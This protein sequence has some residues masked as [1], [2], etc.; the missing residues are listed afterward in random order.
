MGE[1]DSAERTIWTEFQSRFESLVEQFVGAGVSHE[2]AGNGEALQHAQKLFTDLTTVLFQ[3][4]TAAEAA[5]VGV[6]SKSNDDEMGAHGVGGDA[7]SPDLAKQQ[8]DALRS[9]QEPHAAPPGGER[10]P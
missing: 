4:R 6:E 7:T 1:A 10:L 2:S 8:L 9:V 5:K 3:K